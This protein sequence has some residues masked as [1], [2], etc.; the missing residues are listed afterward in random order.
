MKKICLPLLVFVTSACLMLNL[1][2]CSANVSSEEPAVQDTTDKDESESDVSVPEEVDSKDTKEENNLDTPQNLVADVI[3]FE[4][5]VLSWDDVAGASMY[6]VYCGT[7]IGDKHEYGSTQDIEAEI[8]NLNANTRYYFW[9]KAFNDEGSS[10]SYSKY[11]T[12]ITDNMPEPDEP[13]QDIPIQDNTIL[14]DVKNTDIYGELIGRIKLVDDHLELQAVCSAKDEK[15][16][17]F[18]FYRSTT[19]QNDFKAYVKIGSI[20]RNGTSALLEDFDVGLKSGDR[21]YYIIVATDSEESVVGRW[22]DCIGVNLGYSTEIRFSYPRKA[23]WYCYLDGGNGWTYNF[24]TKKTASSYQSI[25]PGT[26]MI[27]VS[28]DN[29]NFNTLS[30]RFIPGCYYTISLSTDKITMNGFMSGVV[31]QIK[32]N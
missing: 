10:S 3:D 22:S 30:H 29:K 16:K 1:A 14:A 32:I 17:V 24:T 4:T 15:I 5:I 31:K 26:H 12:A 28:T 20:K 11:V 21:Y 25:T 19:Y 27:S 18:N 9:V 7:S 13:N 2:S 8:D 6:K 23:T